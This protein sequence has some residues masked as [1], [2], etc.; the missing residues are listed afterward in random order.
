VIFDFIYVERYTSFLKR[1]ESRLKVREFYQQSTPVSESSSNDSSITDDFWMIQINY[2][3]PFLETDRAPFS[4]FE[5][6]SLSKIHFLFTMLNI[7]QLFVI[8]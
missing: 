2:E 4:V 5:E 6:T 8:K 3:H 1:Q 7:S